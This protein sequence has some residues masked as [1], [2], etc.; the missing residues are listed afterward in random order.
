MKKSFTLIELL[1]VIAIIAILAGMLLPALSKAR[2]KARAV[3]CLSNLK[4]MGVIFNIY[5][6]DNNMYTPVVD[7]EGS[8]VLPNADRNWLQTLVQF[9]YLVLPNGSMGIA[10]C[11]DG[12]TL[13]PGYC[14]ASTDYDNGKHME[15]IRTASYGM[16][17]FGSPKCIW[18]FASRPKVSYET[19]GQLVSWNPS[20][21]A[22]TSEGMKDASECTLLADSYHPSVESQFLHVNRNT[23]IN[24]AVGGSAVYR[25]HVGSANLVFADG[26]AVAADKSGLVRYGWT[27][28]NVL[29]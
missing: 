27:D 6:N 4:N 17:A 5:M 29:P 19:G 25:Y 2:A 22:D 8:T 12:A 21:T 28:A 24:T 9:E 11:P 26:H 1:V 14:Q 23:D 13:I 10:S 7:G 20:N 3:T 16:W 15:N 18:R